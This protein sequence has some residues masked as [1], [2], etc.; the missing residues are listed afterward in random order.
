MHF[1]FVSLAGPTSQF[2][3]GT[4]AFSELV[5]ARMALLMD[6]SRTLHP[7]QSAKARELVVAHTRASWNFPFKLART[8]AGQNEQYKVTLKNGNVLV[9]NQ[10][11]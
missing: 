9:F 1:P 11:V 5:L 8:S 3:N 4:H 2:L 10:L 7:L 6:Q